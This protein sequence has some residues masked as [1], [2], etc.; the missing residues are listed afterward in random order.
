MAPIHVIIGKGIKGEG[1]RTRPRASN[2]TGLHGA[3]PLTLIFYNVIYGWSLK[4]EWVEPGITRQ[5][6]PAVVLSHKV[7]SE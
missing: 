2:H 4:A 1:G 3:H 7:A 6:I 5:I